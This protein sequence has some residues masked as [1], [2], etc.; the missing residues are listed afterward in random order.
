MNTSRYST[1]EERINII[2]RIEN[3]EITVNDA[4]LLTGKA[5]QTI[6]DWMNGPR[7]EKLRKKARIHHDNRRHVFLSLP[8]TEALLTV[9]GICGDRL[10]TEERAAIEKVERRLLEIADE[11]TEIKRNNGG[12]I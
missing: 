1:E 11:L 3:G 8:E 4:M 12:A 5:Y 9:I 6:R 10:P 2:Q 7:Y